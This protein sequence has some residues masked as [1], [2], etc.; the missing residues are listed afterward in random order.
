MIDNLHAAVRV[1]EEEWKNIHV[2]VIGDVMLDKYVWGQVE[3]I[4]PE[5]PI[6]IVR[7]TS[8]TQR[9][10]GAANVA[11]NIA[12]LGAKVTITGIAGNDADQKRLEQ[13]LHEAGINACLVKDSSIPTIS[14]LRILSGNQQI[15]RLDT[16]ELPK[17][18]AGNSHN[19]LLGIFR[20][21]VL[22]SQV[23]ILSD[24]AKGVL[25]EPVCREIISV[26]QS[27]NVP[28]I[29]DPKAKDFA[30]YRGATT[31]CPNLA[32]LSWATDCP[33][34][35]LSTMLTAAKAKLE[36]WQLKYLTVT[37]SEKGIALLK[38][39][40]EYHAPAVV[41]HVYDVSGAGD[42]VVATLALSI[43]SGLTPETAVQL[44][45]YA[46]GVV[47]GKVGTVPIYKE[48]LIA[49]LSPEIALHAPEKVLSLDRL[50]NR[51]ASWRAS[52][53]KIVFTNGCYDLLHIGHVT[54]LN[55]A[56]M[57]GDRL[58]VAINSDASVRRL[59]GPSRPIVG[60]KE[61]ASILAALAVVDAVVIFDELTPLECIK[62][63]RP[64]VLVKGGDYTEE[65]VVGA[66]EVKSWGGR[67][68]LVPIVEGFST[69]SLIQKALDGAPDQLLRS[70]REP[71]N[72]QRSIPVA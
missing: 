19:E 34:K 41:R 12:T 20:Q 29:V 27:L 60:E 44:A 6:P 45:N 9:P 1:I 7:E 11:M 67:T 55:Q 26:C 62:A 66:K 32:E 21:E 65:T 72:E 53:D 57:Q 28:V 70:L 18:E 46:A 33:S 38:N 69:T 63:T 43:A 23:V 30:R 3:R 56:R 36:E 71:V 35:E 25:S 49:A 31:I 64:D 68:L 15:L 42:T 54:L 5:G 47:V 14:K 52:G 24:Y 17:Q 58:I 22:K 8:Q 4:S 50:Q 59:K 37:L 13:L 51:I 10:G 16:E 40:S 61:R 2:L 39:N 48:E